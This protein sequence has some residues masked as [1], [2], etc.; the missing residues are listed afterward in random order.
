[1]NIY[2]WIYD[3]AHEANP[4]GSRITCSPPP[5]N[6]DIDHLA[7]VKDSLEAEQLLSSKGFI[8]TTDHDYQGITSD[9]VSYKNGNVNVLTTSSEVFYRKFMAATHVAKRLNLMEKSD[10]ICLFQAVLYGNKWG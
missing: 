2:E 10:R 1:M 3:V 5:I 7:W 9:F 6:T 8:T 4:V